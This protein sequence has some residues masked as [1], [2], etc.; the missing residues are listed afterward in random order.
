MSDT[1]GLPPR[2][3]FFSVDGARIA[4]AAIQNL[5]EAAKHEVLVHLQEELARPEDRSTPYQQRVAKAIAAVREAYAINLATTGDEALSSYRYDKLQQERT[6]RH[7]WPPVATVRSWLGVS[8][9]NE[10][11]ARCHL[12]AAPDGDSLQRN[13]NH[14]F[15]LEEAV[16]AVRE[17]IH[18]LQHLPSWWEYLHWSGRT[19]VRRRS[20]RRPRSQTVFDRLWPEGGWNAALV[21]AGASTGAGR[22]DDQGRVSPA[23]YRYSPETM[24]KTL[25][26]AAKD[27]GEQFGGAEF[28]HWRLR[29]LNSQKAAGSAPQAIPSRAA[30]YKRY[31]TW[32]AAMADAGLTA[33]SWET[34]PNG[35]GREPYDRAL[36]EE[37]VREA[38]SDK[39]DPFTKT[40]YRTWRQE[41]IDAGDSRRLPTVETIARRFG[42][43]KTAH[44]KILG[45]RRDWW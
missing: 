15:S 7:D 34:S 5:D 4:F 27:L 28:D 32:E 20:G 26:R 37:V 33:V 31:R 30:F 45:H 19:D 8:S 38:Y 1:A 18:D 3:S 22:V 12:P 43:W 21:S 17:C 42:G 14:A 9:W 2:G 10:V 29:R 44:E 36:I 13:W 24:R 35:R 6:D 41:R 11:M 39:G 25:R 40:T 23:G 16:A